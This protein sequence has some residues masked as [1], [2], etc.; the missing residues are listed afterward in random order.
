MV[1]GTFSGG[2]FFRENFLGG[3]FFTVAIFPE[4]NQGLSF[5]FHENSVWK[6]TFQGEQVTEGRCAVFLLTL[7]R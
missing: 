1:E 5:F 6:D 3:N 2:S 7:F 4:L